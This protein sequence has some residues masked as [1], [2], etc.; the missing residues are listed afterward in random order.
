MP[1]FVSSLHSFISCALSCSR[2][3]NG[4]LH[5]SNVDSTL[6]LHSFFNDLCRGDCA[7]LVS[8]GVNPPSGNTKTVFHAGFL[9]EVKQN[10]TAT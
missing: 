4:Q 7:D 3:P 2:L 5:V 10:L 1:A 9:L 6:L 8:Q